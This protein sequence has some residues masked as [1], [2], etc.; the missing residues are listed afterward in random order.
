MR[1]FPLCDVAKIGLP[2][3]GDRASFQLVTQPQRLISSWRYLPV[4]EEDIGKNAGKSF[5]S[6]LAYN[7]SV[8][9]HPRE[10]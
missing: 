5:C 1:Y 10:R 2:S 9:I 6:S 4:P 3:A 8:T 7:M